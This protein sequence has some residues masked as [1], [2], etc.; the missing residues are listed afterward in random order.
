MTIIEIIKKTVNLIDYISKYTILNKSG[1][2]Y[3]GKCPFQDH[4][5]A[6]PS[7]V[8]YDNKYKCFGCNRSG[9]IISF[10]EQYYSLNCQQAIEKL[11]QEFN[12]KHEYS[13][14]ENT[15]YKQN[16]LEMEQ[17]KQNLK[18]FPV[19]IKYLENRGILHWEK[20]NIGYAKSG[21][22]TNRII[23]SILDSRKR[24][25][26]FGGRALN[27]NV[28]PKYINSSESE[29]FQKNQLLYY[30]YISSE[31]YI[32]EGYF[33]VLQLAEYNICGFATM[34]TAI[35]ISHFHE[36]WKH[37]SIPCLVFDGDIAGKNAML[38]VLKIV[39]PFLTSTRSLRCI[40]LHNHDPDTFIKT[41]GAEEWK[42]LPKLSPLDIL[43]QELQGSAEEISS[44]REQIYTIVN[45]IEDINMKQTFLNMLNLKRIK[46]FE[47]QIKNLLLPKCYISQIFGLLRQYPELCTI[48]QYEILNLKVSDEYINLQVDALYISEGFYPSDEWKKLKPIISVNPHKDLGYIFT[49]FFKK[50][51]LDYLLKEYNQMPN[52]KL[53]NNIINLLTE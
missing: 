25:C 22:F 52:E 15:L 11:M 17:Y 2:R 49:E 1:T 26:G 27:D 19:A 30:T 12:L 36:I 42:K 5:D 48:Y 50:S 33:D 47:P 51:E 40:L 45:Q 20:Y 23:F 39:I 13:C 32:V 18:S 4:N 24:I 3:S 34:G 10:I 43:W 31:I 14:Q 6:H 16:A 9:D 21:K 46:K 53:W 8:I 29:I 37:C 7:F 28:Y 44:K 41:Y 35:N 38:K